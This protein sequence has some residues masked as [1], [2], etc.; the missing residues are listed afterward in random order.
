[1]WHMPLREW[2]FFKQGRKH[3]REIYVVETY[4]ASSNRQ[5]TQYGKGMSG[6]RNIAGSYQYF[7][8]V[9]ELYMG[10]TSK[11]LEGFFAVFLIYF[12]PL[13]NVGSCLEWSYAVVL[14]LT[15]EHLLTL[16]ITIGRKVTQLQTRPCH[17]C[18]THP[19]QWGLNDKVL[20]SASVD[21]PCLMDR[22]WWVSCVYLLVKT[23]N[24]P[25]RTLR[26][27]RK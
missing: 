4:S 10:V 21:E 13:A 14:T 1:M 12:L 23:V 9:T 25:L 7:I 22:R 15:K 24:P 11:R 18:C 27:L 2:W 19:R 6:V 26:C 20:I 16:E 3:W 8:Y 5:K 17:L